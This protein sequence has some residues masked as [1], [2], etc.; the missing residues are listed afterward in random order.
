MKNTKKCGC[1][2]NDEIHERYVRLGGVSARKNVL[3]N[4]ALIRQSPWISLIEKINFNGVRENVDAKGHAIDLVK[5]EKQIGLILFA[6]LN[7]QFNT[8]V[9][10]EKIANI[11]RNI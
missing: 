3:M 9:A 6:F 2:L 7:N 4:Q 10:V 1:F 8:D 5:I 11:F